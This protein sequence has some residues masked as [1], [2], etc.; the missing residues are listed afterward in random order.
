MP[1]KSMKARCCHLNAP[2]T[3]TGGCWKGRQIASFSNRE[4]A[5]MNIVPYERAP[6]YEAPGHAGMRMRRLQGQ[7]AG[8]ADVV[9]LGL[10]EIEPGGGT[11]SAASAAE[12]FYV[13]IEG[14][15]RVDARVGNVVQSAVLRPLD[16]CRI[17]PGEARQITNISSTLAK[18]FVEMQRIDVP[19]NPG[20]S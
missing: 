15:V 5:S 7:E 14:E 13:C 10:S 6:T 16:S 19:P 4:S 8:P 20:K 17:A 9:W 11:T 2:A 3:L 12:K 18:V 1:S